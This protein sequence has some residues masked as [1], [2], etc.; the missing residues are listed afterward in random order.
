MKPLSASTYT[1]YNVHGSRIKTAILEAACVWHEAGRNITDCEKAI[2]NA[3][4]ADDAAQSAALEYARLDA[5]AHREHAYWSVYTLV[6][7]FS[8]PDEWKG[9]ASNG[10]QYLVVWSAKPLNHVSII[11]QS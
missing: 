4:E 1:T 9:V 2:E 5:V 8:E 3:D 7:G 11:P 6:C 10:M